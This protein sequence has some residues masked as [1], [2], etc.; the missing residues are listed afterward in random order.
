MRPMHR[1]DLAIRELLHRC[2]G[3]DA[4]L[5]DPAFFHTVMQRRMHAVE[6]ATSEDYG[7]LLAASSEEAKRLHEQLTIHYSEF[8]RNT[9]TFAVLEKLVIPALV[10]KKREEGKKELRV[11][12]AA[13]AAGQ[14]A[15]SLAMLLEEHVAA[16][17]HGL[18]Y[19]I[20]ATDQDEAQIALAQKARYAASAVQNLTVKQLARWFTRSGASYVLDAVLQSRVESSVFNLLDDH[21]QVP[22]ASIFGNFDLVFCA[23]L[24]FYYADDAQERILHKVARSL[25]PGGCL[26][27][28]D[29]ERAALSRLGYQEMVPLSAVFRL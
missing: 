5:F 26:V 18:Q 3:I 22:P 16:V 7:R 24:L 20:F 11:W 14:E 1:A 19:R 25:A 6:C 28:G 27:T 21:L 29:A 13:C 9:L 23:N 2:H 12:S 8:M 4:D 10:Q 17:G 15:Y